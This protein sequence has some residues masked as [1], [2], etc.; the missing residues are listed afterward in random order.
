MWYIL[1]TLLAFWW[2]PVCCRKASGIIS[3]FIWFC[4][5]IQWWGRHIDTWWYGSCSCRP[6]DICSCNGDQY[7]HHQ[8]GVILDQIIFAHLYPNISKHYCQHQQ[9]WHYSQAQ[10]QGVRLSDWLCILDKLLSCT[11]TNRRFKLTKYSM[12]TSQGVMT[13]SFSIQHV[14]LSSTLWFQI[15]FECLPTRCDIEIDAIGSS[16]LIFCWLMYLGW[17]SYVASLDLVM[18]LM[19]YI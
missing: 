12:S 5:L 9:L 14:I 3:W 13:Q 15:Y 16:A 11:G 7:S 2:I 1:F 18:S 19:L 17:H 6:G 4:Q 10:V 8:P